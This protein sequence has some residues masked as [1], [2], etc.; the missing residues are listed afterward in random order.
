MMNTVDYMVMVI[1]LVC[2]LYSG[3]G[4]PL[5]DRKWSALVRIYTFG[6]HCRL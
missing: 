2:M 4:T 5:E 6:R 1:S 3:T